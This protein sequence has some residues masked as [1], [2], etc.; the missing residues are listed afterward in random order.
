MFPQSC[1]S[2]THFPTARQSNRVN[3]VFLADAT[4]RDFSANNTLATLV[5]FLLSWTLRA[6]VPKTR[7]VRAT[8]EKS[9]NIRL[10]RRESRDTTRFSSPPRGS[11]F[12]PGISRRPTTAGGKKRRASQGRLLFLRFGQSG[13]GCM[14]PGPQLRPQGRKEESV[15]HENRRDSGYNRKYEAGSTERNTSA[16]HPTASPPYPLSLLRPNNGPL[17]SNFANISARQLCLLP[18]RFFLSR[19]RERE[20]ERE[21]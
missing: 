18:F 13:A 16:C 19:E 3:R 4:S 12:V 2:T 8:R 11:Q 6:L 20:R 9:K 21:R 17:K 5:T 10:E 14:H 15:S 1:E 7:R